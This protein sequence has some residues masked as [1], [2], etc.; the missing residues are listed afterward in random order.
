MPGDRVRTVAVV[1]QSGQDLSRAARRH[2]LTLEPWR[3][4]N[5]EAHPL[6]P[7]WEDGVYCRYHKPFRNAASRSVGEIVVD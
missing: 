2:L 3:L 6:D 4:K 1:H 5:W 7:G